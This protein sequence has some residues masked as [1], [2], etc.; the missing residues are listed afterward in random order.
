MKVKIYTPPEV[1]L[2]LLDGED[3]ISTSGESWELPEVS[4]K[5]GKSGYGW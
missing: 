2:L 3:L 4:T 1:I 5:E